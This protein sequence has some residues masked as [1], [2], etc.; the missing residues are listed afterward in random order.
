MSNDLVK[1]LRGWPK[2]TERPAA[3]KGL[4]LEAADLIEQQQRIIDAGAETLEKHEAEI[5]RLT[6]LKDEFRNAATNAGNDCAKAI[7]ERDQLKDLL[8]CVRVSTTDNGFI[9]VELVRRGVGKFR[10]MQRRLL[11]GSNDE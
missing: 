8:S 6:A 10:A 2:F 9:N 4:C 7:K 11:E 3:T 1:R 5:D